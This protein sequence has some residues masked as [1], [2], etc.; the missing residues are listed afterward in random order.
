MST[1]ESVRRGL[2]FCTHSHRVGV[3]TLRQLRSSD[4]HLSIAL[5]PTPSCLGVCE[6]LSSSSTWEI[7]KVMTSFFQA[8]NMSSIC[9][10]CLKSNEKNSS[11]HKNSWIYEPSIPDIVK[12]YAGEGCTL[13][14]IGIRRVERIC[15]LSD[16]VGEPGSK[17][18]Y[19]RD[20]I[21]IPSGD[22]IALNSNH[23]QWQ[24]DHHMDPAYNRKSRLLDLISI[25]SHHPQNSAME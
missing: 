17:L 19:P 14:V 20:S 4:S 15:S 1:E 25:W 23:P 7:S 13:V 21:S 24:W 5:G 9:L 10:P 8:S 2:Y 3:S 18:I 6:S 12:S 16:H 11:H 22:H